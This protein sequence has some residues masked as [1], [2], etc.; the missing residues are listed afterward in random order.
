MVAGNVLRQIDPATPIVG[1]VAQ[2]AMFL[3][4]ERVDRR[5]LGTLHNILVELRRRVLRIPRPALAPVSTGAIRLGRGR[6]G[7]TAGK[8]NLQFLGQDKAVSGQQEVIHW[9]QVILLE[10]RE[11]I[12]RLP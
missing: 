8:L 10:L 11:V 6:A 2:E 12:I 4:D 9:K 7:G 1:G 5:E 3:L